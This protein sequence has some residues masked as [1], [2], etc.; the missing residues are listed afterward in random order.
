MLQDCERSPHLLTDTILSFDDFLRIVLMATVT[1]CR[2]ALGIR[3]DGRRIAVIKGRGRY[4]HLIH[5]SMLQPIRDQLRSLCGT[6]PD[7]VKRRY[8]QEFIANSVCNGHRS[9][10]WRHI[11][12]ATDR[13]MNVL[14][15]S[16]ATYCILWGLNQ[17]TRETGLLMERQCR[18]DCRQCR[19]LPVAKGLLC[20]QVENG[21]GL[22]R[23]FRDRL[24]H[25][26]GSSTRRTVDP[27]DITTT[28]VVGDWGA[29]PTASALGLPNPFDLAGWAS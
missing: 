15:V 14:T 20:T 19:C 25:E 17:P 24:L 9:W 23:T 16:D 10:R 4:E 7:D 18:V 22:L 5:P 12:Q 8:V 3:R 28:R 1:Y 11:R 2:E 29:C 26:E 21:I 6:D 27:E 13:A